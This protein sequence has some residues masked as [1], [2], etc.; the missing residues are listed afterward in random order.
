MVRL[1]VDTKGSEEVRNAVKNN[2][3]KNDSSGG[4]ATEYICWRGIKK[5]ILGKFENADG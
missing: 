3:K 1:R 5:Q 4:N 2:N